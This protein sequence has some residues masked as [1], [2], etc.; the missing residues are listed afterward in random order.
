M[1]TVLKFDKVVLVKE[2][3]DKF[4][5]VGETFEI[6][7][8]LDNSF[9]LRDTKTRVAIGVV[10]FEDFERCFVHKENFKGW[11]QWTPLAGFDGQT[12]ALYRTN[13]K[14]VQCKFI[15]DKVRA[16]CSCH[17][18]DEFNLFFGVQIAYLR[19]LNKAL[20]K[21]A[22]K[23]EEELKKINCEIMDNERIIQKMVNSLEIKDEAK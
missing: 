11:T 2:L 21:R 19:C 18:E 23:Y 6:A 20:I 3:N 16:E 8:I 13:Y 22:A 15:T 14:K 12:D 9:L 4:K 1:E 7:N 10:S 5:K 17:K